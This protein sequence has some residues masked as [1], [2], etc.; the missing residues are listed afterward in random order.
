MNDPIT[1][2]M[3]ELMKPEIILHSLTNKTIRGAATKIG[4]KGITVEIG[5]PSIF[6]KDFIDIAKD[7]ILRIMSYLKMSKDEKEDEKKDEKKRKN[8][9]NL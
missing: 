3:A 6:Q 8:S 7:G 4:I 1:R 5:N 9:C 2:R